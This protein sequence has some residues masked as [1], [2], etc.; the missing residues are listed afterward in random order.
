MCTRRPLVSLLA[1]LM[2][3][4]T[5]GRPVSV[6]AASPAAWAAYFHHDL[7]RARDLFT[8][9]LRRDPQD[10]DALMGLLL[11]SEEVADVPS[12]LEIAER[13]LALNE[14][15]VA[16]MAAF[17]DVLFPT[18]V[19]KADRKRL[20]ALLSAAGAHPNL[21]PEFK[22]GLLVPAHV[23]AYAAA[24]FALAEAILDSTKALDQWSWVGAFHNI[25][26][27][28]FDQSF[29]P[30]QHPEQEARFIN[31]MHAEVRW[32]KVLHFRRGTQLLL[33][34]YT[35]VDQTINYLQ[36]FVTLAQPG[37]YVLRLGIGGSAKIW[38]DDALVYAQEE[39]WHTHTDH[40]GLRVTLPAGHHRI[41]LQLGAAERNN[42]YLMAR[43][44][45]QFGAPVEGLQES[46][47]AL[48]YNARPD[49]T[50]QLLPSETIALARAAVAKTGATYMDRMVLAKLLNRAGRYLEMQDVM[51]QLSDE[52]DL[53]L[54]STILYNSLYET[55]DDEAAA[56]ELASRLTAA[57][58]DRL[59]VQLDKLKE[60]LDDNESKRAKEL[61]EQLQPTI[62]TE[63]E[64]ARLLQMSICFMEKDM[65]CV[66]E[67]LRKARRAYPAST[68]L[69]AIDMSVQRDQLGKPIVARKLLEDYT[70]DYRF[71]DRVS[72]LA[73]I[74]QEEGELQKSLAL[75]RELTHRMPN[76]ITYHSALIDVLTKLEDHEGA[77]Q[78]IDAVIAQAPNTGHLHLKRAVV[79]E[80]LKRNDEA[81]AAYDRAVQ[82]N[83]NNFSARAKA[84]GMRGERPLI[85]QL[86]TVDVKAVIARRGTS[87]TSSGY[88]FVQL[89]NGF[90]RV[91]YEDG[92]SEYETDAVYQVINEKGIEYLKE[93]S[94]NGYLVEGKVYRA[95]GRI[96]DGERGGGGVIFGKLAVGDVVYIKSRSTTHNYG[97]FLGHFWDNFQMS[98]WYPIAES[99]Y[100]LLLPKD[101]DFQV[102]S[103]G[104][105][106]TQ[107]VRE[108]GQNEAHTWLAEDVE[109]VDEEPIMPAGSDVH[110]MLHLTTIPDWQYISD[111]YTELSSARTKAD[112]RV[113]QQVAELFPN[114]H[115]ALTQEERARRIYD[116]IVTKI[117]YSS[118]PFRQSAYVPQR[119]S[120][121][122]ATHLGDCKDVSSLYVAMAREVG[123]EAELVLV[124]TRDNGQAPTTLPSMPFNHCIVHLPAQ[125]Q[126]LELTD[127]YLPFGAMSN[128]LIGSA[129]LVV[130][131]FGSTTQLR[132]LPQ[133]TKLNARTVRAQASLAGD[134]LQLD[135]EIT[136]AGV[137]AATTRHRYHNQAKQAQ[138]EEIRDHISSRVDKAFEFRNLSFSG[139]D[140]LSDSAQIAY[141]ITID[142]ATNRLQDMRLI[143]LPWATS[144]VNNSFT[145]STHRE[146]NLSL[147]SYTDYQAEDELI[148]MLIPEA[149]Q[150][151]EL[152]EPVN[153]RYDG[154]EYS[155]TF[156]R[157]GTS[158]RAARSFRMNRDE[159][160]A[161]EFSQ[162]A[163]FF[164]DVQ[165]ADQQFIAFRPA[166]K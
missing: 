41:L 166:A 76:R 141:S 54:Y 33:N 70:E 66:T 101:M 85:E 23:T 127:K 163:K 47:V 17:I 158:L 42:Q 111:W 108:L 81:I 19:A 50:A 2:L 113:R 129:A 125:E 84:R 45:D 30:L 34:Q 78:E 9:D 58:P 161:T 5:I 120:K 71:D 144:F 155:L 27:S 6:Q 40:F 16:F 20:L 48:P 75:N 11:L 31:E 88:P 165:E 69:L 96:L 119:A 87:Y 143:Q 80:R 68:T 164:Q 109:P 104:G 128:E 153:Y 110:Q 4:L 13:L 149:L 46:A 35:D 94:V 133:V 92:I 122:L 138:E 105:Q 90:R 12:R 162:I 7:I 131:G 62:G 130:T 124:N 55:L 98:A 107:T 22:S 102:K 137:C 56:A 60:A 136:Y 14:P 114:G 154:L 53:A 44:T 156:T 72:E 112:P 146:H 43:L 91:V 64:G 150:L 63:S 148:E 132:Q 82:L 134:R 38:I 86:D 3:L 49:L 32:Q 10:A 159:F 52:E 116:F 121:T 65:S 157:L 123:V 15:P 100:Q 29:G 37:D 151:V 8:A 67:T 103:L 93:I 73:S 118:L 28:G 39:E 117:E 106:V 18:L 51:E 59:E 95:D 25:H 89:A 97:R 61:F 21:P 152:P 145:T 160:A 140:N 26:G 24:D 57:F 99:R 135:R 83:P 115:T 79:L 147:W 142:K 74:Y 77:L 36:T 126:Y 1:S 139:L